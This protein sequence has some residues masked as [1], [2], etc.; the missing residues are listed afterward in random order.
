LVIHHESEISDYLEKQYGYRVDGKRTEQQKKWDKEREEREKAREELKA[1]DID[2]YYEK[3]PWERPD[4]DEE[5]EKWEK[6][7]AKKADRRR[8]YHEK[9]GWKN[10]YRTVSEKEAKKLEQKRL[11]K[12]AGYKAGNKINLEP[13]VEGSEVKVEAIG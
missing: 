5:K 4:T 9:H 1:R 12:Q 2:A 3:Y 13:F 10:L 7:Y 8:K 6:I 11:S